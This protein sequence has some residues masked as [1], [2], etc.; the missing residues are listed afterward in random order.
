V[1]LK[2]IVERDDEEVL[3]DE[4]VDELQTYFEG[5]QPK[6]LLTTNQKPSKV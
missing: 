6:I 4:A 1:C 5:K 2:T 3:Q